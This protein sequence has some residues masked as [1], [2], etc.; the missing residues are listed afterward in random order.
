MLKAIDDAENGNEVMANNNFIKL[1]TLSEC[2]NSSATFP[3]CY[4][5][6][7]VYL[8]LEDNLAKGNRRYFSRA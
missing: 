7:A 6:G 2:S 3:G 5:Q 8:I 4:P 1:E